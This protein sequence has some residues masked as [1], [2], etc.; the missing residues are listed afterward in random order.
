MTIGCPECGTLE[1]VP[2]LGRRMQAR[3]AVCDIVLE[4]R[5]GR[6][7]GAA[8]ACALATFLLLWPANLEPL[9]TVSLM[10]A[11]T[12]SRLASG[13]GDMWRQGWVVMAGLMGLFGLAVAFAALAA[14][15]GKR[16]MVAAL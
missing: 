13:I 16:R 6:S 7:L 4:R 14:R 5:S 8:L 11:Q 10:G 2:P 12:H 3:C 1:D 9:M 15:A